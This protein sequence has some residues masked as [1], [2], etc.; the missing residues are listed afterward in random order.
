MG[1]TY[2]NTLQTGATTSRGR[3]YHTKCICFGCGF[4]DEMCAP[5]FASDIRCCCFEGAM[6]VDPS[7][8]Q[9][10]DQLCAARMGCKF[11]PVVADVTNPLVDK[12]ELIVV[13]EKKVV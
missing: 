2:S 7:Q 8:C 5:A 10:T 11:L 9:S 12:D 6:K 3:K 4:A 1:N 13:C